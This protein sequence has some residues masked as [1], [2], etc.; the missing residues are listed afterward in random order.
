ME[1][2]QAAW[3]PPPSP[4]NVLSLAVFLDEFRTYLEHLILTPEPLLLVG[5]LNFRVDQANDCDARS[6]LS[7]LDSFDLI[8]HVAGPTHHDGHTLDLVITRASENGIITNCCVRQR[9]SDHFA[10]HCN[11]ALAKPPLE[12]KTISLSARLG[13]L[14]PSIDCY[15]MESLLELPHGYVSDRNPAEMSSL[16]FCHSCKAETKFI[17]LI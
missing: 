4:T 1:I 15:R 9:I 14:T 13:Q 16:R 17:C 7:V 11:L 6:F 10:V 3:C 2:T 5:D 12:R 8:Q